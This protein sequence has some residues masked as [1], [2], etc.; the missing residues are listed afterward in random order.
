MFL[1]EGHPRPG[2][3]S[4]W[5]LCLPYAWSD[6]VFPAPLRLWQEADL[7]AETEAGRPVG[8]GESGG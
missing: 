7:A 4:G 3:G 2:A 6:L 1:G 5:G 8:P